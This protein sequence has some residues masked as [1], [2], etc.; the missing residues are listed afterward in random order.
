MRVN[1]DPNGLREG[2]CQGENLSS[3]GAPEKFGQ[4]QQIE[5]AGQWSEQ[6]NKDHPS[7]TSEYASIGLLSLETKKKKKKQSS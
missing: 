5:R 2:H 7:N 4:S 1:F 3:K 6:F